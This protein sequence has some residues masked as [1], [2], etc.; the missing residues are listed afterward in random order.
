MD[1]KGI[2]ITSAFQNTVH[3]NDIEIFSR[4]NESKCAV[5]ERF[6]KTLK[7]KIPKNFRAKNVGIFNLD[8]IS[9]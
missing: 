1:K 6:T 7:I 5:T 8:K 9:S 4:N 3:F 2:T